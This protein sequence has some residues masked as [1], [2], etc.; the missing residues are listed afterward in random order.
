MLFLQNVSLTA[1]FL[2]EVF[3]SLGVILALIM[4]DVGLG[5]LLAIVT[6]TWSWQ[7]FP[8]FLRQNVLPYVGGLLLLA[9]FAAKPEVKAVFLVSAAATTTKFLADIK[10]KGSRLLGSGSLEPPSVSK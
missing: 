8:S 9:L 3:Y 5:I 6:S 1:I 4:L 10:T 2:P 7:K